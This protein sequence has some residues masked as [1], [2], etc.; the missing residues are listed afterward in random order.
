[1]PMSSTYRTFSFS[2]WWL[3]PGGTAALVDDACV[4]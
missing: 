4:A 2:C 1:M 3:V